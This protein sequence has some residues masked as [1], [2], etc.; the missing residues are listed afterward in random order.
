[1]STLREQVMARASAARLVQAATLAALRGQPLEQD[2]MD[3]AWRS[4]VLWDEHTWGADRSISE[5][6][7]PETIA[8]WRDKRQLVLDADSASRALLALAAG[9]RGAARAL[10]IWNTHEDRYPGVVVVP[11]SLS[12]GGDLV[13]S[14]RRQRP[15]PHSD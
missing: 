14:F 4:V 12:R 5:P 15:S 9:R 8:Q 7:S 13:R 1:M 2:H 11:D 6:D 10:D 3:A